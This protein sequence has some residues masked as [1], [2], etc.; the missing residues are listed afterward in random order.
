[1]PLCD[2]TYE[3]AFDAEFD[4]WLETLDYEHD[5]PENRERFSEEKADYIHRNLDREKWS[6]SLDL[7]LFED[8]VE[9]YDENM[10]D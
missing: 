3:D 7:E 9:F 2:E 6:N 10:R 8:F 4:R 1:M 5:A